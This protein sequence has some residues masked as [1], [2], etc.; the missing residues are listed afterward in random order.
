MN[1]VSDVNGNGRIDADDILRI[2]AWAN[3]VDND[4]NGFTDDLFGWDFYD[5]DNRPSRSMTTFWLHE[6]AD[7]YHGTHVSGTIGALANG[8]GVVRSSS[9]TCKSCRCVS[10]APET[11]GSSRMR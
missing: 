4:G 7:S 2:R 11:R 9:G 3:R 5:D 8:S 1:S 10:W 6:P